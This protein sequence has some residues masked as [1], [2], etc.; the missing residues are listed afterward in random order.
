M[1]LTMGSSAT[2]LAPLVDIVGIIVLG[3]MVAAR[4]PVTQVPPVQAPMMNAQS[5][6]MNQAPPQG[7][8]FVN[9]VQV[10][11]VSPQTTVP[12][13]PFAQPNRQ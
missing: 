11:S 3:V 13:S 5:P 2:Q 9:P 1:G 12:P 4:K 10:N 6:F 8:V 7:P